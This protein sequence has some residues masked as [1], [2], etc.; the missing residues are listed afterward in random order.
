VADTL[1]SA[2][3]DDVVSRLKAGLNTQAVI[4]GPPEGPPAEFLC[5]VRYGNVTFDWGMFETRSPELTVTVAVPRGGQYPSEYRFINDKAHEVA[6]ALRGPI[7]LAG[8]APITGVSITEPVGS[9]YAGTPSA[10]MAAVVT[11]SIETKEINNTG[12]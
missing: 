7:L 6:A 4:Y 10:I 5:W 12:A 1:P 8:E 9:D 11:I 3:A 2:I